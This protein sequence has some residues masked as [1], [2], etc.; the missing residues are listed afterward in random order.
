[1]L[2]VGEKR[3]N[4]AIKMGVT[5]ED[6]RL[7]AKQLFDALDYCGINPK[8]QEF[9]NWFERGGKSKVRNYKGVVVG[10]GNKVSKALTKDGIKHLF[11]YHPATRGIIRTKMLYCKHVKNGLII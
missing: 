2:F 10:M 5:W 1:M 3:S 7:A 8:E 9:C 6:G 4:L 11:I